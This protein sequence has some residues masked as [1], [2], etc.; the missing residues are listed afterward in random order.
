MGV[1]T[2]L[3]TAAELLELPRGEWRYELV[4]GELITSSPAGAE[5]GEVAAEI[6]ARLRNYVR[7]HRLG[8]T[9]AA[10]TGFLLG[11]RPDS[12]RAPDVAFVRADRVV[13]VRTY[14][15]GAPDL[16][17]EVLSPNDRASEVEAKVRHWLRSGTRMVMVVDPETQTATVH[18]STTT[19][20]LSANDALDGGDVVPGW[21]LP[22]RELFDRD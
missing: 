12:V 16:A 20:R 5:H 1:D 17:V 4:E 13:N 3:M 11:E 7:E 10:E 19:V 22:L 14:F 8:K 6:G 18:R 21:K 9:Y 15:P 2:K